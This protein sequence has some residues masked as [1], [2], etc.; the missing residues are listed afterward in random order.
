LAHWILTGFLQRRNVCPD[1]IGS[2]LH[3]H[4]SSLVWCR[5]QAHSS[6]Q[7]DRDHSPLCVV[8]AHHFVARAGCWVAD[9]VGPAFC[10]R[11][12]RKVASGLPEVSL[13]DFSFEIHCK[14]SLVFSIYT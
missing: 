14:F 11:K 6:W 12:R 2:V 1:K 7:G 3:R 8:G 5:S 9:W 4:F 13:M 10:G